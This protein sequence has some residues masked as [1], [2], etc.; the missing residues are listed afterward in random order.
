MYTLKPS[1]LRSAKDPSL[2]FL[3]PIFSPDHSY[4]FFIMRQ[5]GNHEKVRMIYMT[6]FIMITDQKVLCKG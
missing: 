1:T 4:F 5:P 3:M 6:C 2:D